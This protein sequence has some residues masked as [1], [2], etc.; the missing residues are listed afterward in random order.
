MPQS[1]SNI[2][3]HI[4]FSTQYRAPMIPT[5]QA[6]DLYRYLAAI[7]RAHGCPAH[8]IGG[9]ENHVHI[10]CSLARTLTCAK[11]VE[12]IKTGSSKWMKLQLPQA[13]GFAWQHGY[14]A[15]SVGESQLETL[16]RYIENQPKHHARFSFEEELREML[17]RYGVSYD[18]RYIWD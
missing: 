18:E 13:A 2:I 4:I 17:R 14:G 11:L 1:L 5:E 15:F 8:R 10:C 7:A 12:E 6:A 9:T 3:L 16:K